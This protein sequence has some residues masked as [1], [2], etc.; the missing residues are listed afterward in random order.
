M[1]NLLDQ[2]KRE[3]RLREEAQKL[4]SGEGLRDLP[5][6]G[7]LGNEIQTLAATT[8]KNGEG[9]TNRTGSRGEGAAAQRNAGGGNVPRAQTNLSLS[10]NSS[11]GRI[12]EAAKLLGV[13][14]LSDAQLDDYLF[15]GQHDFLNDVPDTDAQ[16]RYTPRTPNQRR[17]VAF[18]D[19]VRQL[20]AAKEEGTPQ[21]VN[22]VYGPQMPSDKGDAPPLSAKLA[23]QVLSGA[24]GQTPGKPSG[25]AQD[26]EAVAAPQTT[27]SAEGLQPQPGGT[28]DPTAT[29]SPTPT[30][31]KKA[32]EAGNTG[33]G[34]R[35]PAAGQLDPKRLAAF[36]MQLGRP[37]TE[38]EKELIQSTLASQS[39]ATLKEASIQ[40]P[41]TPSSGAALDVLRQD[42]KG[43]VTFYDTQ[44]AKKL[45]TE[46]T[47]Q[48]Q[49]IRKHPHETIRALMTLGQSEDGVDYH[50]PLTK[51]TQP[52]VD[53]ILLF[54]INEGY[55][56]PNPSEYKDI[57]FVN[58]RTDGFSIVFNGTPNAD[59][60]VKDG[61]NAPTDVYTYS[62]EIKEHK[63]PEV[64]DI[65][66]FIGHPAVSVVQLAYN[67]FAPLYG[68][69]PI[70]TPLLSQFLEMESLAQLAPRAT[71]Y[72]YTL[73]CIGGSHIRYDW[74]YTKFQYKPVEVGKHG[75][76]NTLRS[77]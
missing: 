72:A 71:P 47:S 6:N 58:N 13:E 40:A 59:L 10:G 23:A 45:G 36:E 67:A 55:Y 43:E 50:I 69:P 51:E 46:Y 35:N 68:L 75:T 73:K 19:L 41:S 44:R 20:L 39:A 64:G 52:Y 29:P 3:Q 70:N 9:R 4:L 17:F 33:S 31:T 76:V 38:E 54:L 14:N 49:E 18:N 74:D 62:F 11:A 42:K 34:G 24:R 12:M 65:L 28:P 7:I 63:N 2:N 21:T 57:L 66:D 37:L 61:K 30:P 32:D 48:A 15:R 53:N 60:I 56:I 16:G 26:G 25:D 8:P 27:P 77:F 22:A 5:Q 1:K